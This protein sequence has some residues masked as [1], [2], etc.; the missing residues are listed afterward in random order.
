MN[1]DF[2]R[3]YAVALYQLAVEEGS[4]E[5]VFNDLGEAAKV[6]GENPEFLRLISNP[7]LSARERAE[8]VGKVFGGQAEPI[9]LNTV[10]ILAEKRRCDCVPKIY[11][12]YRRLYCEDNGILPV[13]ATSAVELSESQRE[14]LTEKLSRKT[15]KKILLTLKVDPGCI[16]GIRLEYDG[17][18]YDASVRGR[19]SELE[20]SIKN[21]D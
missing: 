15:G 6:F 9:L 20:R 16:G 3:E 12:V 13:T 11:E 18:R 4:S 7:R 17:K 10:K 2:S 21:S 14:K 5:R 8:T 1:K 19:L